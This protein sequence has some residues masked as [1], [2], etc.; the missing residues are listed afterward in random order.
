MPK[1]PP[2]RRYWLVKSEPD[3]YAWARFVADRRTC[4]NCVRN[5]QARNLLRDQVQV[6]DR[7]FFYHSSCEVPAIVG[8]A[9]VVS[10]AYPDPTQFDPKSDYH[11]PGS[12]L[13]HPRW[14]CVDVAYERH[15]RRPLALTELKQRAEALEDFILLRRGNRLSLFP[16]S[17]AHA[18]F[19]LSLEDTR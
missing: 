16:V 3:Q 5:Y 13:E 19:L 15:L 10:T 18:R 1:T 17:P 7:V 8:L 11:D 6:D 9:R 12:T 14:L 4:W 2:Q